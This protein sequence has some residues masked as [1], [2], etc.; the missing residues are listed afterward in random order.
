MYKAVLAGKSEEEIERI[1][2]RYDYLEI[3]PL[4]NNEFMLRDNTVSSFEEEINNLYM[5]MDTYMYPTSR[6]RLRPFRQDARLT[7][8]EAAKAS[9]EIKKRQ[10][11]KENFEAYRQYMMSK[12][13]LEHVNKGNEM[14]CRAGKSAFWINWYGDMT[15]CIF[16]KKPGINVFKEG[17]AFPFSSRLISA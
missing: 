8:E 11:S 7:S 15:P 14:N 4:G 2:N 16:M 9:V 3:Q 17:F 12:C 1:A 10:E 13:E 5:K 6:E